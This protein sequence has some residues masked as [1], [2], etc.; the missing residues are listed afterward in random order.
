MKSRGYLAGILALSCAGLAFAGSNWPHWRGPLANGVSDEKDIPLRW[1]PEENIHWKLA[2]PGRSGATPIIWSDRIFV[3]VGDADNIEMWCVN[4]KTGEVM[5]KKVLGGGNVR[6][7]KQNMSSPSPVTDGE[8][9]WVMTGTGLLRRFDMDGKEIWL[10][11]IQKDYGAFGLNW[12]YASSPLLHEDSLY[13]QVLHGMKTDDPSYLL[14]I[15]RATGKTLWRVERP[16]NAIRESPDSYTTPAVVKT[17]SGLE[18]VASGGDCVTGHDLAT[19][20]ELWRANGLNPE[21]NPAY[22]IVAS[23]VVLDDL[24][25]VP[26]RVRPLLAIRAG[27]RGDVTET[28]RVWLTNNGPDVPTPVSDGKLLYIVND[29]GIMYCY[30]AQTGAEVYGGQRI[31]PGSYSASPV[32][33]D[34]RLYVTSEEGVTT[35]VKAGPQFEV[36]AENN[37][38]D[39]T[40]SS[41]VIVKGQIFLRT[42]GALWAIGQPRPDLPEK[43]PAKAPAKKKSE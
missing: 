29:R 23:P 14:R 36:L 10:R 15:D 33:A 6:M 37:L 38:N 40:L 11:D 9:V 24:V 8:S 2:L 28:H 43:A 34:G 41:P 30:D 25:F 27:G 1:S 32:I 18:L 12:G 4:R 35:V 7:R 5:W 31:K 19:G 42:D 39:Y 16:T 17:K 26:S 22:R 3:N 13:I 21:N 20:K